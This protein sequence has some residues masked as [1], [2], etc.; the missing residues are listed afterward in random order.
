MKKLITLLI[1]LTLATGGAFAAEASFDITTTVA[2]INGMKITTAKFTGSTLEALNN[3][4]G[5]S[6]YT[7]TK[8]GYQSNFSGWIS[9]VSNNREGYKVTMSATAMTSTVGTT[10]SYI[11][12]TVFFGTQLTFTTNGAAQVSPIT[13]LEKSSLTSLSGNSEK[14]VWILTHSFNN[15]VEGQY[16]GT[17]TLPFKPTKHYKPCLSRLPETGSLFTVHFLISCYS[18]SHLRSIHFVLKEEKEERPAKNS[19]FG[20]VVAGLLVNTVFRT[21]LMCDSLGASETASPQLLTGTIFMR[22]W[23]FGIVNVWRNQD[24]TLPIPIPFGPAK[25]AI[26]PGACISWRRSRSSLR[27]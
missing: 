3:A 25:K 13:V 11:N 16:T 22:L 23:G 7:V 24:A 1:V 15:A 12:Y 10:T 6:S 21:S 18:F 4:S 17:V 9:V 27:S 26:P 2:P 14:L 19:W 8:S 5:V 20:I